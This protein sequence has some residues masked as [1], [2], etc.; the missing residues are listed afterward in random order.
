MYSKTGR[1]PNRDEFWIGYEDLSAKYETKSAGI[2]SNLLILPLPL[3]ADSLAH[4][5]E[6]GPQS[7]PRF[8]YLFPFT[9]SPFFRSDLLV[10]GTL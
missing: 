6:L 10:V 4:L 1:Q 7:T 5:R 2:P 8:L 9:F 3:L